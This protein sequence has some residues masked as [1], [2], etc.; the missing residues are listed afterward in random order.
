VSCLQALTAALLGQALAAAPAP[1]SAAVATKA[2]PVVI[3]VRAAAE[4]AMQRHEQRLFEELGF[5]LDGFMLLSQ[6]AGRADFGNV[7]LAE[8]IATVLPDAKANEAVAV[9]WLSFPLANQMMLHLVTLGPGRTLIRTIETDRK[10]VSASALALMAR[11]MLGTAYLFEPPVDVPAEVHEVVEHVKA[12]IPPEP[13]PAAAAAP[14]PPP[15]TGSPWAAWLRVQTSFPVAGGAGA[16]PVV[17][18]GIAGE[19]RAPWRVDASLAVD[20]RYG[21]LTSPIAAGENFLTA[22]ATAKVYR[23]F[24]FRSLSLGPQLSAGVAYAR[25][26]A[27]GQAP[28]QAALPAL[29]AGLEL[30]SETARGPSVGLSLSLAYY[31]V[32]AELRA[33]DASV[34]YRLPTLELVFGLALGWMGF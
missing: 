3:L 21:V 15:E 8:Q 6:D 32:I 2:P 14:P 17:G 11:E 26:T 10:P 4:P 27:T 13:A 19:Y 24:A 30:R 33:A 5:A 34:I 23:G 12:Q 28:V 1:P 31:P 16:V 7:S 22:G 29:A 18:F 20:A 9:I 25:F